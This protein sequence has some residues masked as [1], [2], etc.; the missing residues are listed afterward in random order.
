MFTPT[1]GA[2]IAL[3]LLS[4]AIG[5]IETTP[6]VVGVVQGIV[7]LEPDNVA[8]PTNASLANTWTLVM[9]PSASLAVPAIV[10]AVPG[11][12]KALASGVEM[13]TLGATPVAPVIEIVIFVA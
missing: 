12:R 9:L 2:A 7:Q 10:V 8:F 3:P 1:E 13:P 6:V 5:V 11:A 4:V